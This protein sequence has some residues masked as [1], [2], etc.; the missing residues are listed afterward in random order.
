MDRLDPSA[1]PG[2]APGGPHGAGT[3]RIPASVVARIA[4]QAAREVPG[5]GSGAGGVL[6]I[7]AR[8]D[9]DSPPSASCDLYGASAV[10]RLDVGMAFPAALHQVAAMLHDHVV[11]RVAQLT[12]FEVGRLDIDITWLNPEHTGRRQLR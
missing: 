1:P 4:A 8:R 5:I 2:P 3:T 9:F 10:I 12:G 7:G 11:A 6:G